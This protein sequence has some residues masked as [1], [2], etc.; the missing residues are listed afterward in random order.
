MDNNN[1]NP[2][3]LIKMITEMLNGGDPT[4]MFDQLADLGLDFSTFDASG[5][6]FLDFVSIFP[7]VFKTGTPT[8]ATPEPTDLSKEDV[9]NL[10]GTP[11]EKKNPTGFT[12]EKPA[13]ETAPT[14]TPAEKN[15][16]ESV[17]EFETITHYVYEFDFAGFVQDNLKVTLKNAGT[18]VQVTGTKTVNGIPV[19]KTR[20]TTLHHPVTGKA[21]NLYYQNGKVVVSLNKNPEVEHL[22]FE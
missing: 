21:L 20:E 11:A 22:T 15:N 18:V 7:A 13:K 9:E 2:E 6:G 14:V 3:D 4:K 17:K 16:T 1:F 10:F 5:G 12:A 19:T 8:P